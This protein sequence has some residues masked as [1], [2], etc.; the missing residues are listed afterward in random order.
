MAAGS[1][2]GQAAMQL[3]HLVPVALVAL[4]RPTVALRTLMQPTTPHRP[5]RLAMEP[6]V[7][8]SLTMTQMRL[9]P[10]L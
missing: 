5:V 10:V 6:A 8:A 7:T 4:L 9:T 3:G 2:R 1:F